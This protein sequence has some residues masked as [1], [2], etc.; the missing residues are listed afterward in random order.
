MESKEKAKLWPWLCLNLLFFGTLLHERIQG[1]LEQELH[2][3]E[4]PIW[5]RL[6]E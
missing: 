2:D 5:I 6:Q 3:I 1:G 4:Q